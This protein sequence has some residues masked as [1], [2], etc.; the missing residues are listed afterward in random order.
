[1]NKLEKKD[2]I[3]LFVLG[4]GIGGYI[5]NIIKMYNAE[6]VE[7]LIRGIGLLLLPLGSVFGYL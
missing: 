7:L 3:Q 2:V 1:M 4:L 5:A 6:Q